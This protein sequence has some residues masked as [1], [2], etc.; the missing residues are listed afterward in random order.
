[1]QSLRIIDKKSRKTR[2]SSM[3]TSDAQS[4]IVNTTPSRD[5]ML[6]GGIFDFLKKKKKSDEEL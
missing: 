5:G 2:Q 4:S 6:Y 1:M 3:R